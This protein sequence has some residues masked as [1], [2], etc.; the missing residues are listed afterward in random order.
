MPLPFN[1]PDPPDCYWA[2]DV[3]TFCW[4]F[5]MPILF[6]RFRCIHKIMKSKC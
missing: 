4:C 6:I 2:R 1:V 5:H 3:G